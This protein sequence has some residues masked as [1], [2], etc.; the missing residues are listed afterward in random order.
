MNRRG[1]FRWVFPPKF[2]RFIVT[3]GSVGDTNCHLIH[4]QR[5]AQENVSTSHRPMFGKS[6]S[7]RKPA[8]LDVKE[9]TES[10]HVPAFI[11]VKPQV[12]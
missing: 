8:V 5:L 4:R 1:Y 10:G 6:P 9:A 12:P 11:A 3:N 2:S 7:S